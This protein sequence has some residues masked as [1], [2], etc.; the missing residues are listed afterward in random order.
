MS[1]SLIKFLLA[2]LIII[3]VLFNFACDA[4]AS[5]YLGV[6]GKFFKLLNFD[7]NSV[8]MSHKKLFVQK[9]KVQNVNYLL[10]L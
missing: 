5:Y 4:Q 8:T 7:F 3:F 10:K 6:R 1:Q 9:H 2:F